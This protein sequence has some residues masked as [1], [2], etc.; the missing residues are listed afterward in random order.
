[1]SYTP[2]SPLGQAFYHLGSGNRATINNK[3]QS[4][5]GYPLSRKPTDSERLSGRF[6]KINRAIQLNLNGKRYLGSVDHKD[7]IQLLLEAHTS[8]RIGTTYLLRC[9]EFIAKNSTDESH[10]LN[11]IAT[12]KRNVKLRL[13]VA[14]RAVQ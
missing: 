6:L 11:L 9:L 8:K 7:M 12:V 2:L 1:M 10:P 5:N 13:R 4:L 3:F 14:K